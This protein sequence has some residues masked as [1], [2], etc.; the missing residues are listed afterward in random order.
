[1]FGAAGIR[2]RQGRS[3]RD[4]DLQTR[5]FRY[6][7]SYMIYSPAYASLPAGARAALYRRMKEILK[8][9]GDSA[10]TDI[11]DETLPGWSASAP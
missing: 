1:V 3:L 11:L 10:V 7:C 9:R 8:A 6:R 5:L 2:D 4:L